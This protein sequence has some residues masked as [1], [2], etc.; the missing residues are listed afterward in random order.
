MYPNRLLLTYQKRALDPITDEPPCGCWELNS[1][2]L[3]EQPVLLN[4][5]PSLKSYLDPFKSRIQVHFC[6]S[7][8][9]CRSKPILQHFGTLDQERRWSLPSRASQKEQVEWPFS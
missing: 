3:E 6:L 4:A 9:L 1:R 2:P 8:K 7:F 5:G